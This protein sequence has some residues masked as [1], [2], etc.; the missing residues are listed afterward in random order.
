ML[1]RPIEMRNRNLKTNKMDTDTTDFLSYLLTDKYYDEW[2]SGEPNPPGSLCD[3]TISDFEP[4]FT[5]A[6]GKFVIGF[7]EFL[8]RRNFDMERLKYLDRSFGANCYCS[9]DGS[10]VGFFDEHSDPERTLGDELQKLLVEYSGS[11]YR[12]EGMDLY[13]HSGDEEPG[14]VNLSFIRP[15]IQQYLG[16]MFGGTNP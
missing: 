15:F 12:F 16:K 2:E 5:E 3:K 13:D 6:A 10:G 1:V 14:G 8:E 4:S 9:L 11:R 7:R